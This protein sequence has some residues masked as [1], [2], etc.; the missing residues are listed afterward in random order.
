MR[1]RTQRLPT[2]YRE[3]EYIESTTGVPSYIDCGLTANQDS[4]LELKFQFPKGVDGYRARLFGYTDNTSWDGS[5]MFGGSFT[6]SLVD[7]ALIGY[8]TSSYKPGTALQVKMNIHTL[9]MEKNKFYF[10]GVLKNTM[11]TNT[12]TTTSNLWLFLSNTTSDA[13]ITNNASIRIFYCKIWNNTTLA[14]N[15]IPCERCSDGKPGLYD[16]VNNVFYVNQGTGEFIKGPY[17]DSYQVSLFP[18]LPSAYQEVEYIQSSGTQ[19]IILPNNLNCDSFELECQYLDSVGEQ[20]VIGDYSSGDNRWE[21]FCNTNRPYYNIWT[22]YNSQSTTAGTISAVMRAILNYSYTS[23]ELVVTDG[24][25]TNTISKTLNAQPK[26]LFTYAPS[27]YLAKVK[28][29]SLKFSKNGSIILNMIPCYRKSDNVIGLYDLVGKQFYTNQGTGTFLKGNNVNNIIS[30]KVAGGSSDIYYGYNNL[31]DIY[32]YNAEMTVSNVTG[33][34]ITLTTTSTG[35]NIFSYN[36]PFISGHK[37]LLHEKIT[38]GSTIP[39]RKI[40][41]TTKNDSLQSEPT[42]WENVTPNTTKTIDLILTATATQTDLM[43]VIYLSSGLT[44]GIS[45]DV[46]DIYLLDL[47]DW[48]GV[49]KEPTTVAEFKEKFTKEYYGFCP[50][51]IKLTQKM[52][53][54]EPMYGYNQMIDYTRTT[55]T[56]GGLSFSYNATT[57]EMTVNNTATDNSIGVYYNV[58]NLINTH[59]YLFMCEHDA[60]PSDVQLR[61]GD[62]AYFVESSA[63][64]NMANINY[65]FLTAKADV[66]NKSQDL[67]FTGSTSGKTFT[68]W[69]IR[70]FMQIDLTD[71][72]GAGSEPTTLTE[73]KQTFPNKYYPYSKK[74]LLNR[75]MINKLVA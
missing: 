25:N 13:L 51:S 70:N 58:I 43:R 24:T 52:I 2:G 22:T 68:N 44:A 64:R 7:S 47:T 57:H 15:M 71:W 49:G 18:R 62:D 69:K 29:F 38:T 6:S 36:I 42:L 67:Y 75:Y 65:L 56:R 53:E 41:C 45:F 46:E 17:K 31:I 21:I 33:T 61:V 20:C 4:S 12:F 55:D 27:S 26:Y 54:E 37:Y 74:R 59:K 9:K 19:Y 10:D 66:T 30:C 28:V 5:K 39:Y 16:T 3:L 40:V 32:S 63:N 14:R 35:I 48:Y 73:F 23:N 1:I 34:K 8:G 50:T 72:Y 60:L 11:T